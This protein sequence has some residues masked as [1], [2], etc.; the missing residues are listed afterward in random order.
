[1]LIAP[2][3]T[4]TPQGAADTGCAGDYWQFNATGDVVRVRR[5]HRKTL[6]KSARTQYLAPTEQL[7]RWMVSFNQWT[8]RTEIKRGA[9][10]S[11]T[12]Q[13]KSAPQKVAPQV[14]CC[15]PRRRLTEKTAPPTVQAAAPHTAKG[16]AGQGLPHPSQVHR[17]G[18]CWRR[19]GSH[20]K[21]ARAEPGAAFYTPEQTR[22][23][24]DISG[25]GF[26]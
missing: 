24:P 9:T 7:T 21:R 15:N 3:A 19:E 14:S 23:G 12:L 26:Q 2:T 16:A 25:L 6:F 18:D 1:M 8:F 5:Q 17:G 20:W 13:P 22:D 4:L 10:V 11:Q